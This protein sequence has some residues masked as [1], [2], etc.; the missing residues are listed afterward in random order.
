M[1]DTGLIRTVVARHPGAEVTMMTHASIVPLMKQSGWFADFIVDNRR[2]YSFSELKRLCWTE[3]ARRKWDVVY[4]LQS[5]HRTLKVY[6][7]LVRFLTRHPLTWGVTTP[8]YPMPHGII[9][10]RTPA[11][12]AFTWG[13]MVEE[14]FDV[15]PPPADI[16]FCHGE[17]RNFALLPDRYI[18]MIPGCSPRHP[19]KRWPAERYRA[20][21]ERF[22][23]R[24]LKSVVLG[25]SA[26]RAEIRAIASG[27]PYAVDFMDKASLVDI[28]DLARGAAIVIGNDTG[29][30]HMA[31][32]AGAKTVMLF[33]THT[34]EAAAEM[35][36]VVNLKGRVITDISVESAVGALEGLMVR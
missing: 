22:G 29:P 26:E 23:A 4:D 32:L 27:N 9:L 31:R 18:L 6:Y 5:S 24:G 7:P 30:S 13:R 11:K 21:S 33:N 28:P 2:G 10:R 1:M 17:R 19:E 15:A 16:G 8:E 25:T 3:L 34:A 35:P 20:V 36:T 14:R 12:R